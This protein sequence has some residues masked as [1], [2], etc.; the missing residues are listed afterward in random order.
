MKVK[1]TWDQDLGRHTHPLQCGV[2]TFHSLSWQL[3]VIKGKWRENPGRVRASGEDI[4][5]GFGVL[6]MKRQQRPQAG[7]LSQELV[8]VSKPQGKETWSSRSIPFAVTQWRWP[9]SSGS[10]DSQVRGKECK[11]TRRKRH[12]ESRVHF[13]AYRA[14]DEQFIASEMDS[15]VSLCN[16]I[17][18]YAILIL[19]TVTGV[20]EESEGFP[21]QC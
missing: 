21:G 20:R 16:V 3:A 14:S 8:V 11:H 6:T 4:F 7:S 1:F 13:Q 19:G 17:A 12:G 9:L 15:S 18:F 2:N 5:G 10:I